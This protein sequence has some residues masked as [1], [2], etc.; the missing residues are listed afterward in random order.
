MVIQM[1]VQSDDDDVI[2]VGMNVSIQIV[3]CRIA[4]NLLSENS[5]SIIIYN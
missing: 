2:V 4:V 3:F 1:T 5:L